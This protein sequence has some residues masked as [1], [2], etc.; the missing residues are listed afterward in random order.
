M[1][2]VPY[3]ECLR[4]IKK[5]YGTSPLGNSETFG[6]EHIHGFVHHVI[7]VRKF[8][9][10]FLIIAIVEKVFTSRAMVLNMGVKD[11]ISSF[12]PLP[13]LFATLFFHPIPHDTGLEFR[14]IVMT[15]FLFGTFTL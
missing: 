3:Q 8:I 15:T 14:Y 5:R 2:L 10:S 11:L 12:F 1:I 7:R 13:S 9:A 6:Y 4:A